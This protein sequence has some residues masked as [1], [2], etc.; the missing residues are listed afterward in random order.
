M[1]GS[2]SHRARSIAGPANAGHNVSELT[3][4]QVA[5]LLGV[6]ETSVRRLEGT[7]LHPIRRGR[8]VFFDAQEVE[9]CAAE[10]TRRQPDSG[11]I[12]ARAFELF[13]S[14]RDF[15][16]VVIELRQTPDR[17][18]QLYREYA[19]GS[20]LLM[21]AAVR[22]AIEEL[23]ICDEGRPIDAGGILRMLRNLAEGNRRL[24]QR[25]IDQAQTI[26]NLR[27][28]VETS[29]ESHHPGRIDGPTTTEP[30]NTMDACIAQLDDAV[31][32]AEEISA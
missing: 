24:V 5:A 30:T 23:G 14:G 13:R 6:A 26:E 31:P 11:E 20:D 12:A 1:R 22:V 10:G 17:V 16:D 18:R 3:R 27:R 15:R 32:A 25:T 29:R 19:L 8:F 21:P 7:H 28:A 2:G 4:K 9:R